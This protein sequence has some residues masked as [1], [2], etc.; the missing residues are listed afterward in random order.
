M[1]IN[2][3]LKIL[4]I[5]I[6]LQHQKVFS[7][8]KKKYWSTPFPIITLPPSSYYTLY[9]GI[10]SS[11][12]FP[13][14]YTTGGGGSGFGSKLPSFPTLPANPTLPN[15]ASQLT[16]P[17]IAT[18][19]NPGG[20][21][22]GFPPY[23]TAPAIIAQPPP[24]NYYPQTPTFPYQCPPIPSL[25]P[26]AAGGS[27]LLFNS[28]QQPQPGPSGVGGISPRQ[29]LNNN[30]CPCVNP[31]AAAAAGQ[32]QQNSALIRKGVFH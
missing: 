13:T 1:L 31:R 25:C 28:G 24:P 18:A 15:I 5:T 6:F 32:L 11:Y 14:I 16:F 7:F 2:K 8:K 23:P 26:T 27:Q 29:Y 9:P 21:A 3:L 4:L 19:Y 30:N 10:T 20:V 12:T 17:T 22:G